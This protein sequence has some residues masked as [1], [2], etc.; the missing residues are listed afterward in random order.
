MLLDGKD[1][2][3]R[4]ICATASRVRPGDGT[5]SGG[6][7]VAASQ[8]AADQIAGG[9]GAMKRRRSSGEDYSGTLDREKYLV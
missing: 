8:L 7:T 4:Q 1:L 6:T 9:S 2:N 3:H 5:A